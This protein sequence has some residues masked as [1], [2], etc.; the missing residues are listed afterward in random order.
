MFRQGTDREP[1]PGA[2]PISSDSALLPAAPR[3]AIPEHRYEVPAD[4]RSTVWITFH[5]L[6]QKALANSVCVGCW[7]G[8]RLRGGQQF[9]TPA[10]INVSIGARRLSHRRGPILGLTGELAFPEGLGLRLRLAGDEDETA[11]EDGVADIVIV[12]P[13]VSIRIPQREVAPEAAGNHW[14][15]LMMKDWSGSLSGEELPVGRCV[16]RS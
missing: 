5:D 14:V 16:R 15:S 6:Q 13:N 7:D 4:A 11:G 9:E 1:T 3:I 12:E 10:T 2:A 8:S